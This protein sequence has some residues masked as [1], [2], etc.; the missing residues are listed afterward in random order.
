MKRSEMINYMLVTMGQTERGGMS[1][2]TERERMQYLLSQLEKAGMRPPVVG[3]LL[4]QIA[5]V[6]NEWEPEDET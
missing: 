3:S 2:M 4:S 6:H 1:E 5:A